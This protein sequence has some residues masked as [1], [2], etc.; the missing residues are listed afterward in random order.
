MDLELTDEQIWLS[1]SIDTLLAREWVPAE[2]ATDA[3]PD[4]Q[5]RVWDELVAFG[6]LAVGREQGLGAVEL[7]L[8]ARELGRRLA[9]VPFIP[10]TAVRMALEPFAGPSMPDELAALKRSEEA[11]SVAQLEPGASWAARSFATSLQIGSHGFELTG[12]KVAIEHLELAERLVVLATFD[13]EPA[14][15]LLRPAVPGVHREPQPSFDETVPLGGAVFERARVPEAAVL[16]GP[17]AGAVIERLMTIGALLAAAEAIGAAET[18]LGDACRYAGER[19]QFGRPIASFQSLRHILADMYVRQASGWSTVLFAAAAFDD[20]AP[21]AYT[22][23]S[24]AKAYV[25]RGSR[26]VAHG[27]MQV[28]GGIAFTAEHPAHRFLRR[29]V[30]R[31]QQF[32]D[33]PHHE[34]LLGRALAER[35]RATEPEPILAPSGAPAQ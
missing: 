18:L 23:A 28:F 1:E 25:S 15:A 4:R 13:G 12:E 16:D 27:A 29:I 19:R 20:D 22:T 10:S 14:L 30:V 6:A 32:G 31:E 21:D 35:L 7:C 17:T 11:I 8:I 9:S 5:R 24:V 34:R 3:G 2:R 33:A 26:E